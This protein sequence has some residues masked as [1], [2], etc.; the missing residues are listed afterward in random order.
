MLNQF[1]SILEN[2]FYILINYYSVFYYNF[3]LKKLNITMASFS[4]SCGREADFHQ[5]FWNHL[6]IKRKVW[7]F[8]EDKI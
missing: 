3:V 4:L 6:Q 7:N 5:I 1:I 2:V 8:F